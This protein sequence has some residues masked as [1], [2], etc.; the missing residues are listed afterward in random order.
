MSEPI[1]ISLSESRGPIPGGPVTSTDGTVFQT[2]GWA[3]TCPGCEKIPAAG[4][5]ITKISGVWW[6]GTC[7]AAYLRST[8]ANE[9][10]L[11]LGHQL[12]R[13]PS[14][15]N[16]AETKAIV[17]NLLRLAGVATTVPESP[18]CRRVQGPAAVDEHLPADDET[19]FADVVD[20]FHQSDLYAAFL[21][22]EQRHPGELPVVAGARMW[23]L[24]DAEQQDR[25]LKTLLG[26]Y[27]ELVRIQRTEDRA[28]C[29]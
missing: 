26:A 25:H 1:R 6:H 18:D 8:G 9:A 4:Q 28:D 2:T 29:Q 3:S 7:G 14:R 20:G 23:G 12:E 15:F 21:Q 17:H 16:N 24:L 10:W 5:Q 22:T 19:Q 13:S 11:A 27:V